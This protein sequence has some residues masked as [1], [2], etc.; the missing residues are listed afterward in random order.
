MYSI[1]SDTSGFE[2]SFILTQTSEC[3]GT[4]NRY[5]NYTVDGHSVQ[6][7]NGLTAKV[8]TEEDSVIIIDGRYPYMR[9][10]TSLG[11]LQFDT[12]HFA[13]TGHC[14]VQTSPGRSCISSSNY[15]SGVYGISESCDFITNA[16]ATMMLNPVFDIQVGYDNLKM[17]DLL[18]TSQNMNP[19]SVKPGTHFS[20]LADPTKS[21]KG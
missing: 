17:E 6:F 7:S 12:P 21:Y 9:S 13:G 14:E 19:I 2:P 4:S 20:W 3:T 11:I 16:N 8:M 10:P 15:Y 18:I 1:F 5:F